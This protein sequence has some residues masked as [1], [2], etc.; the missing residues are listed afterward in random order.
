MCFEPR[1][2]NVP[3]LPFASLRMTE[4]EEIRRWMEEEVECKHLLFYSTSPESNL[5]LLSPLSPP[6]LPLFLSLHGHHAFTSFPEANK[7]F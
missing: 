2:W 6:L 7:L 5:T 4:G 1:D 3:S